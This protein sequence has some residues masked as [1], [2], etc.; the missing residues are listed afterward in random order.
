LIESS[1]VR[2]LQDA[3]GTLSKSGCTT[4]RSVRLSID[5]R[6]MLTP[7]GDVVAVWRFARFARSTQHA[8]TALNNFRSRNDENS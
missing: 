8:V 3:W 7:A 1:E 6:L 2:V 4:E 5:G